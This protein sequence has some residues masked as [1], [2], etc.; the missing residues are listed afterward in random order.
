MDAFQL[1]NLAQPTNASTLFDTLK[2]IVGNERL[3]VSVVIQ[4]LLGLGL[5]YYLAKAIKYLVAI[6]LVLL[7]GA[8][9]N[10]WS[11]GGS[12]KEVTTVIGP[13]LAEYKDEL[14]G[15]LR[16]F[17]ALLVGPILLGFLVGVIVGLT[18]R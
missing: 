13:A 2:V 9:L 18:R 15:L 12:L 6:A 5:G 10:V 11:F 3:L 1:A 17:G 4:F 14:L 8:I 7:A 16:I